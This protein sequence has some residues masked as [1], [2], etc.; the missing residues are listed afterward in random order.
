[1]LV[2]DT[3]KPLE[4]G[5]SPEEIKDILKTL[6]PKNKEQE[7]LLARKLAETIEFNRKQR[8]GKVLEDDPEGVFKANREKRLKGANWSPKK[9]YRHIASIPKEMVYVAEKIWGPDVLTDPVKFKQ[10]FVKDEMGQYCLT[11]DPKTI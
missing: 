9:Q 3:G 11:V 4:K 6:R 2:D 7:R 8:M 1:M 10:A 5:K